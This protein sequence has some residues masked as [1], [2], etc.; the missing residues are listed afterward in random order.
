[1][2]KV[3]DNILR[4]IG[5]LSL[6]GLITF[7]VLFASERI[8]APIFSGKMTSRN[9]STTWDGNWISNAD[10]TDNLG[11]ASVRWNAGFFDE[12]FWNKGADVAS[13]AS[14]FTDKLSVVS[15]FQQLS[16]R[17]GS[18]W[19]FGHPGSLMITMTQNFRQ[20]RCRSLKWSLLTRPRTSR[21]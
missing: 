13:A 18:F 7:A 20:F 3:F 5:C 19:S 16:K 4:M 15:I 2:N 11:S 8:H 14:A 9:N 1:M 10:G 17:D 21:R 6:S 12:L